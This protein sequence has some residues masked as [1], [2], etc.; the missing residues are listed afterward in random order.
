MIE[1]RVE[2]INYIGH[3]RIEGE[4]EPSSKWL[5]GRMSARGRTESEVSRVQYI[6]SNRR[7]TVLVGQSGWKRRLRKAR[8]EKEGRMDQLPG[9]GDEVR[10]L[11]AWYHVMVGNHNV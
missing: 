8:K 11:V 3:G 2:G 4:M 10:V 1:N 7:S 9:G 6:F 5:T